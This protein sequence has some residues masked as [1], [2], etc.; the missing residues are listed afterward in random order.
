MSWSAGA[1]CG[2][3]VNT[4]IDQ[5]SIEEVNKVTLTTVKETASLLNPNKSDLSSGYTSDALIN[6]PDILFDQPAM[7]FRSF[8]F[9]GTVSSYHLSCCF[10]TLFKGANKDPTDT[11]SH[12]A[13]AGSSLN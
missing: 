12:R 10:M 6:A 8:L 2:K 9:H 13:I 5:S 7:V 11:N 3:K 4:L 1:R